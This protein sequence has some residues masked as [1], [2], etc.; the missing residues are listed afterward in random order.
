[1]YNTIPHIENIIIDQILNIQTDHY[2]IPINGNGH[3]DDQVYKV[4]DLN[5]KISKRY[6]YL[7]KVGV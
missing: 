7:R 5:T 6:V 1:M 3:S 4:S 2:H